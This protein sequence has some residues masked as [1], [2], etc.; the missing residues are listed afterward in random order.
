MEKTVIQVLQELAENICD[1]FC[2]Y[3]ETT[4]KEGVC[5]W[6]RNGG[7]CPLDVIN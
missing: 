6:I 2:K 7:K 5:D 1:D 3:Q 4:D